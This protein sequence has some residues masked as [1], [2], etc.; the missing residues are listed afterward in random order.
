MADESFSQDC[1]K[2]ATTKIDAIPI[3]GGKTLIFNKLRL[4]C[5]IVMMPLSD[6]SSAKIAIRIENCKN[7]GDENEKKLTFSFSPF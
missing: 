3:G 6:Y 7:L 1:S 4:S 5:V 2:R